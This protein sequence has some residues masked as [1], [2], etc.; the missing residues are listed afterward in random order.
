MIEYSIANS[1]LSG[2]GAIH[3]TFAGFIEMCIDL[4]QNKMSIGLIDAVKKRQGLID[5]PFFGNPTI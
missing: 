3:P 4:S 2:L 1:G 5:L